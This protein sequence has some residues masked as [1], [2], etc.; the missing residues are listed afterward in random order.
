MALVGVIVWLLL[1]LAE[2]EAEH[3]DFVIAKIVLVV[4]VALVEFFLTT[5]LPQ[6]GKDAVERKYGPP[7]ISSRIP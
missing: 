7:P 6:V 2:K 1:K 3:R 4:V 5:A